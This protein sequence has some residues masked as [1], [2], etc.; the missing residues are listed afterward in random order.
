MKQQ[1]NGLPIRYKYFLSLLVIVLLS[2]GIFA[3]I[4]TYYLTSDS[5]KQM[6]LSLTKTLEQT[7]ELL[8][9]NTSM[10]K[11]GSDIFVYQYA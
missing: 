10:I 8:T 9:Y 2:F 4:N 11:Y 5:K 6:E 1:L 3:A 7:S